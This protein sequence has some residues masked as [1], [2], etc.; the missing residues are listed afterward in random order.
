MGNTLVNAA[1]FAKRY[2]GPSG[3]AREGWAPYRPRANEM[4]YVVVAPEDV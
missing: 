3:A 1:T 2:E 4:R